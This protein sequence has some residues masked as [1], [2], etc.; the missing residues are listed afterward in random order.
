MLELS[1]PP[2]FLG[3]RKRR[4][5]ATAETLVSTG[6]NTDL[7]AQNAHKQTHPLSV[8]Q[9]IEKSCLLKL[10]I[11]GFQGF[12]D[13]FRAMPS[14]TQESWSFSSKTSQDCWAYWCAFVSNCFWHLS[15]PGIVY[16]I[17]SPLFQ[18]LLKY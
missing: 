5:Q 9:Q 1:P 2:L 15:D 13:L 14:F 10:N 12:T 3:S 7:K 11:C 18:D 17:S 16:Y 6:V 4:W 8:G